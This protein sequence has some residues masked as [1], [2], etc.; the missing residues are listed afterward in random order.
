MTKVKD[1]Q[2]DNLNTNAS[3]IKVLSTGV[4]VEVTPVPDF[5]MGQAHA[6]M[7]EPEVPYIEDDRYDDGRK[8]FNKED[9]QYLKDAEAFN[10]ALGY[11]RINIKLLWGCTIV[12]GYPDSDEWLRKL[13]FQQH[14]GAID[15]EEYDL[16]EEFV[17]KFLYLKLFAIG[18][19]VTE[20]GGNADLEMLLNALEV[21]EEGVA[22][23]TP[24]FRSD[25]ER[26]TNPKRRVKKSR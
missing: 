4:E 22:E 3:K 15:L 8:I 11:A 19:V 25:E 2:V 26:D 1:T 20:A 5:L 16:N 9:P 13:K 18:N 21:T 6:G 10:L 7:K 17:Q 14:L 23:A 24:T 12:K